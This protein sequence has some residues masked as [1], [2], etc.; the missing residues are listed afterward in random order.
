MP[1]RIVLNGLAGRFPLVDRLA[2]F[3]AT[4]L[5]FLI[6]LC[7]AV[8]WFLPLARDRGKRAA[9]TAAAAVIGGQALNLVIAHLVFVPRPFMA[10]RVLL[11]V[12]AAHDSSFPSDPPPQRS[13][14]P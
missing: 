8:W 6:I 3:I 4:D 2:D 14:S 13:V 7:A 10:H 12:N 9:L 5:I 1:S 11:L